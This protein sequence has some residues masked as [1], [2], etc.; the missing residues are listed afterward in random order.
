MKLL[1]VVISLSIETTMIVG[2]L[3]ILY[4]IHDVTEVDAV[5][6]GLCDSWSCFHVCVSI[7]YGGGHNS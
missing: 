1:G 7:E 6:S 4:P 3:V 5:D 2:M